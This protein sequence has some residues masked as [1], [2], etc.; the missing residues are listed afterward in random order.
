[1]QNS[2]IY[3]GFVPYQIEI[4]VGPKLKHTQNWFGFV[5]TKDYFRTK[6]F[7]YSILGG[8]KKIIT[9][10][11]VFGTNSGF[12]LPQIE[13][14]FVPNLVPYLKRFFFRPKQAET[15]PIFRV[16]VCLMLKKC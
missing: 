11:K 8:F 9:V 10:P 12:F 7:S 2:L 6:F 14:S 3:C 16:S 4:I 15:T 5:P 13:F 1:M